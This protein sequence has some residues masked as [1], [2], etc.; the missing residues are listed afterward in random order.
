MANLHTSMSLL[1]LLGFVFA[2]ARRRDHGRHD[3]ARPGRPRHPAARAGDVF[4][5]ESLLGWI[6]VARCPRRLVT[7]SE[8]AGRAVPCMLTISGPDLRGLVSAAAC[9]DRS[10]SSASP[11][12]PCAAER[13]ASA[14]RGRRRAGADDHPR[15]RRTH[16]AHEPGLVGHL[17]LHAARTRR[18]SRPGSQRA[19]PDRRVAD[20]RRISTGHAR[21]DG[22]R[23]RR[24]MDDHRRNSGGERI[25]EFSTTPLGDAGLRRPRAS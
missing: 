1:L 14:A 8:F 5:A 2:P 10:E 3:R 17:R 4:S 19:Q 7:S 23:P 13:R 20:R 25:W 21:R 18:R 16:P 12:R 22:D 11:P 9:C 6:S 24:R 15:R